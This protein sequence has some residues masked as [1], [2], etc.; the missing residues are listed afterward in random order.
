MSIA[1]KDKNKTTF[2]C[3]FGCFRWTRMPFGLKNAPFY[4]CRLMD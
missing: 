4:F 2:T 1:E 3:L